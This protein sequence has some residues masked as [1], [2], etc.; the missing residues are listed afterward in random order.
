MVAVVTDVSIDSMVAMNTFTTK[1]TNV[2]MVTFAV[3][4]TQ[5]AGIY[6]WCGFAIM[7]EVFCSADVLSLVRRVC[8]V[9][10]CACQV[11]HVCLCMYVC[12]YV[13][14][15]VHMYVRMYV[16]MDMCVCVYVCMYV[17]MYTRINSAPTGRISVKFDIGNFY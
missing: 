16:C 5:V 4:F 8:K 10:K 2:L 12:M 11:R 7:P 6:C 17:C 15:Y 1:V 14:T 3:A 9:A 13:Y